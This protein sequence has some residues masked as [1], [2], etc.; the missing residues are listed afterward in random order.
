MYDG[1]L[2][3]YETGVGP[4]I[5]IQNGLVTRDEGL[6]NAVYISI[7]S[8]DWWGNDISEDSE[9]TKSK[10]EELMSGNLTTQN[11]LDI[12]EEIKSVLQWMIDDNIV[13]SIAVSTEVP[14]VG[15]LYILIE[16][17]EPEFSIKYGINWDT[18]KVRVL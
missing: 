4:D 18:M 16:L 10:L 8:P 6:E 17:S 13:K 5:I 15:Y 9:K 11:I 3:L 12:E 14:A 2:K 1:D 7:F